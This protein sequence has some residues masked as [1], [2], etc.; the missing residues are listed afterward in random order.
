M[1]LTLVLALRHV[2]LA[3]ALALRAALTIKQA[4]KAR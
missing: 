3:L 1:A 4:G 2:A